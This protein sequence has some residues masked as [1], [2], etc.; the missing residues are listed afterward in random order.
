MD[1]RPLN[2][3]KFSHVPANLYAGSEDAK[4]LNEPYNNRW[5]HLKDVIVKLYMGKYGSGGK[6]MTIGLVAEFMKEH[7]TF[8]AA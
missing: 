1:S 7:Y 4:F 8:H 3:R 2:D 5:E 6:S